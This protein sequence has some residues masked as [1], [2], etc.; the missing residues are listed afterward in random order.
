MHLIPFTREMLKKLKVDHDAA[1]Y[2]QRIEA[3]VERI[4]DILLQYAKTA[5]HSYCTLEIS[6]ESYDIVHDI[7]YELNAAFP[8]CS[9]QRKVLTRGVDGQM[10]DASLGVDVRG[11]RLQRKQFH[12]LYL[13]VDWS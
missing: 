1:V 6:P 12:R 5:R 13:T 4:Y 3:E 8:E 9:I 10:Y 2:K 11:I 7:M